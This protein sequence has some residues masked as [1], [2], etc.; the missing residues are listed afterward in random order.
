MEF[1]KTIFGD[2]ALT[3]DQMTEAINV[4]NGIEANRNNQIKIGNL[5]GG[6]YISKAKYDALQQLFDGKNAELDSANALIAD[7]K[8]STNGNAELQGKVTA[9]ET[10]IA[11]LQEDLKETKRKNALR[12]AISEAKGLDVD[13]LVYKAEEKMKADGKA[14]ELDENEKIKGVDDLISGLKTMCPNQFNSTDTQ[15]KV[16]ENRLPKDDPNA[17]KVTKE[18]F[19]KMGYEE[20]LKLKQENEELFRKLMTKN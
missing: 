18:D 4:Y 1:L 12:F 5:G 19:A 3:Y 20:R 7:L 11:Q 15:K 17:G 6:D 13:Y 10:Q 8:Q 2:K 16:I 9:Y 14:F